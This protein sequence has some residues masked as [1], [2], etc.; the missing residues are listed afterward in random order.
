MPTAGVD[1]SGDR[2]LVAFGIGLDDA[3]YDDAIAIDLESFT[4]SR[5]ELPSGPEGGG[6]GFLTEDPY[7]EQLVLYPG[8]GFIDAEPYF[9]LYRWDPEDDAVDPLLVTGVD[10]P[11]PLAGAAAVG[12]GGGARIYG[13][14]D[15]RSRSQSDV[16]QLSLSGLR[17]TRIETTPDAVTS[18]RPVARSELVMQQASRFGADLQFFSGRADDGGLVPSTTWILRDTRWIEQTLA[19][20]ETPPAPR[21]GTAF[22][23]PACGGSQVGYF[24]GRDVMGSYR[25]DTGFLSCASGERECT[26]NDPVGAAGRAPGRAW[27]TASRLNHVSRVVMYGGRDRTDVLGDIRMLDTC[28]GGD[29]PWVEASASGPAPSPRWGHSMNLV[30]VPDGDLEFFLVFG[31]FQSRSGDA[32]RDAGRLVYVSGTTFRW[33]AI[34]PASGPDDDHITERGRHVAIWDEDHDRL[35]VYG[36]EQHGRELGDLWELRI[37]P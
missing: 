1:E 35:L 27:A 18:E 6:R 10:M 28:G 20:G 37:R 12:G 16:W 19:A 8:A 13:G 26:W 33:E 3:F 21:E 17:W 32:A 34:E 5:V 25:D 23:N 24:G 29:Q 14:E 36:G 30:E 7:R 9:D 22:F 15:R 11:P 2:L 4:V 31:G